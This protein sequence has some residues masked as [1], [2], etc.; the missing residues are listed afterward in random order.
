[1]SRYLITGA[2]GF[3]GSHLARHLVEKGHEVVALCRKSEGDLASLGVTIARGDILDQPSVKAA[4]EGCAGVFHCAGKVSRKPE[5]AELLYRTNVDGTKSVLAAARAAGVKRLVHASTSG[6]IAISKEPRVMDERSPAPLELLGKWAYYR[7][8]LYA[9]T[10]ALEQNGQDGGAFE[11]VSV[12]PSL[13]LGPGD[14]HGSSTGDVESFL[15]GKVPVIPAGGLSFVD[16]RDVAPAMLA[17]MEKGQPGAR[18]LMTGANMT[19]AAFLGRI[20]R[21]ADLEP[22]KLRAPKGMFLARVGVSLF[23]QAK[24]VL[25]LDAD[26][27]PVSAEMGQVFW[28][29]DSKRAM[30]DLGF[31]PRDPGETLADTVADLYDR[32]RVW[33]RKPTTGITSLRDLPSQIK[34]LTSLLSHRSD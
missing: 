10:A 7:T 26:M 33:P 27:D 20:A 18:Y 6:T 23:D 2:T 22:P 28:Y 32:G 9:E 30:T 17:A 12:N 31:S 19:V 16:V 34:G 29:C 4:A 13:L 3:L 1:M 24:K 15:A 21:I 14:L 5:D 8:K 25:P 11:V